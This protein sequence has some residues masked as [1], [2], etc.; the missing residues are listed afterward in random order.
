MKQKINPIWGVFAGGIALLLQ[1]GASYAVTQDSTLTSNLG[2][3]VLTASFL[4]EKRSPLRL[5]TV[6]RSK[7]EKRSI[8]ATYPELVKDIP[9]IYA[10]SESGSYGDARIN[11]RGFKQENISVM[12]NGIPI[13]G[14]V[15]GNMF[16]NNWLGLADATQTIQV[17][18]GI[19]GSMLSDNSVGGT[20]NIITSSPSPDPSLRTSLFFTSYGQGKSSVS[21]NSGTL[22]GGWNIS[23]LGSYAF[24]KGYVQQTDV[25]SWAYMLNISKKIGTKH[26]LLLTALG[27]PEKHEQRSARLSATE[28][29]QYGRSYNKN[30]GYLSTGEPFNLSKN[31]YH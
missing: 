12:L 22:K 1:T 20:I 21:M 27:S 29:E 18:K 2:E 31:F 15:T 11:I 23:L 9:G 24:G 14:L 26:T 17:Q 6:N 13:S 3:V 4:N 8:G 10:T 5:S 25:N 7:I 16:W 30:W 28:V 19:G